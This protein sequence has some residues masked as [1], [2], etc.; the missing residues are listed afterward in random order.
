MKKR[1]VK[2]INGK[3]SACNLKH[4]DIFKLLNNPPLSLNP[5]KFGSVVIEACVRVCQENDPGE[6]LFGEITTLASEEDGSYASELATTFL[7]GYL[8]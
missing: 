3:L 7:E 8:S 1:V 5:D 2:F 4:E 6:Q